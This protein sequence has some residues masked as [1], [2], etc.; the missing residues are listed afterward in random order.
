MNSIATTQVSRREFL[1]CTGAG[2][3]GVALGLGFAG[4]ATAAESAKIPVGLQLYSLRDQCKTDLPGMLVAVSKLGYKGVEFAG[5]HG[6]KAKELR[7][8]LDDNGLV[9]CG[10]HA[11]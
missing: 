4:A 8:V 9:A 11:P 6:H 5:Y 1:R 10:T 7:K 2:A 3:A